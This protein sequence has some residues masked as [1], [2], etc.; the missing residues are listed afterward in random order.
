MSWTKGLGT[1]AI[2]SRRGGPV[3]LLPLRG[4]WNAQNQVSSIEDLS[5]KQTEID[6]ISV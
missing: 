2:L 4:L 1:R 3:N 6:V 5:R